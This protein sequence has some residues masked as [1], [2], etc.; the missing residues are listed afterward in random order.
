MRHRAWQL[1]AG[2][3][4]ALTLCGC[5]E[6]TFT[7]TSEPEGA[8]VYM[9]SVEVGRTPVTI[10]FTWYADYDIVLRHADYQTLKTHHKIKPP[11]YDVPPLDLLSAIAPWTYHVRRAAHFKM[12]PRADRTNEELIR[13][14]EELRARNLEAPAK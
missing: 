4:A 3:V 1:V 12:V 6:R 14:A 10:P 7:I 8:L 13:D 11:I 5:V 2:A 9:S